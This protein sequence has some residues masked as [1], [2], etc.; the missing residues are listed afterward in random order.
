MAMELCD[1]G[2]K[3][4]ILSV[5]YDL[6]PEVQYPVALRQITAAYMYAATFGKPIVVVGDSAGGHL[7][8]SLLRHLHSP[9]AQI[10]AVTSSEMPKALVLVSPWVNLKNNGV[11]M[12]QNVAYDCVDKFTL[13][14]WTRQYLGPSGILDVYTDHLNTKNAWEGVLPART[15]MIG[16]EYECFVSDIRDLAVAIENVSLS[17]I[18][19]GMISGQTDGC[20]NRTITQVWIC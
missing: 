3:C 8:L 18:R 20:Y 1:Q 13:D 16:G 17:R 15:L 9:H 5:D 19:I 2:L 12:E 14:R 11:S 7:C 10:Q 6:S 4:S